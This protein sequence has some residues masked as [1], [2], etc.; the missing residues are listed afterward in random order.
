MGELTWILPWTPVLS[1]RLATL[2]VFPQM[3]YWGLRAPITPATTGPTLIPRKHPQCGLWSAGKAGLTSWGHPVCLMMSSVEKR[4]PPSRSCSVLKQNSS[5][6]T[7]GQHQVLPTQGSQVAR[8]QSPH[9]TL[10]CYCNST[11]C[12]NQFL[13]PRKSPSPAILA[14]VWRCTL[15]L[16]KSLTA[17]SMPTV[18]P[19]V[20]PLAK[21]K[22]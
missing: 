15:E 20:R 8:G 22:K 2:T 7:E 17:L 3:S 21:K 5:R 10:Q 12:Q 13:I 9:D 18:C 4:L 19:Q 6:L 16:P 14:L 1:I 11:D